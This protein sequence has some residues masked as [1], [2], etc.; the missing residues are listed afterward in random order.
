MEFPF[1]CAVCSAPN[2][3]EYR[4]D[5]SY[6]FECWSC[7]RANAATIRKERFEIL[8]DFGCLAFLDGYY[9]EAVANFATSL[10]RFF[11][12]WIRTIRWNRHAGDE[13]FQETWK[14]MSK[15]SELQ[16]GAFAI[17]YL[18]D[19]G[20]SPGFLNPNRLQTGFRNAVVHSGK[21]PT[22]AETVEYAD[23]VHGLIRRLLI[24]LYVVA[25]D[26]VTRDLENRNA[27]VVNRADE[28]G[29]EFVQYAFDGV[30]GL[31]RFSPQSIVEA[32]DS[33][34]AR[35]E[36]GDG[37]SRTGN[38]EYLRTDLD[39]EETLD[40]RRWFLEHAFHKD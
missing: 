18:F 16:L 35:Q 8:F 14:L 24:E 3:V 40:A 30:L 1:I 9:R 31:Y 37:R 25:P 39:F 26:H 32:A 2:P 12:F 11:E 38:Y 7:H 28:E 6:S 19:T 17:Q 5:N 20:K 33:Y 34:Q 29:R 21:I 36:S 10:E 13:P 15:R 22:R 23:L 4:D 27:E